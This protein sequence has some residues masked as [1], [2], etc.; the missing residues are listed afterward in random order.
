MVDNI[1]HVCYS[2]FGRLEK[3]SYN[4]SVVYELRQRLKR[5]RFMSMRTEGTILK[6]MIDEEI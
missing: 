5:T 2:L 4:A 6:E 3:V 1:E